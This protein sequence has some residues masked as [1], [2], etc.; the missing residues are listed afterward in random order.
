MSEPLQLPPEQEPQVEQVRLG[1]S[2]LELDPTAAAT[3]RNAFES[4]AAQYSA[5]LETY[6]QQA[7]QTVGT[8]QPM[9]Q[10]HVPDGL[11]V[12]DPDLLFQNKQAWTDEFARS[13]E[14]RI[15]QVEGKN[16]QVAQGLAQAFQQ[17]LNRRD[18][19]QQA[20]QRYDAA[21]AEMLERRGLTECTSLVQGILTEKYQ[22]LQHLPLELAL[23]QIGKEAE[24]AV[25]RIRSGENWEL[26]AAHTQTGVA[27]K[28]PPM[29]RTT[30]RAA[31]PSAPPPTEQGLVSPGGGLGAMG[32]IIRKRQAQVMGG[33]A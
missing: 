26:G 10:F 24:V 3:V 6:R 5:A 18:A 13:L 30:R 15:G 9:P 28:P 8:P 29:L 1:D 14:A 4:L 27:P 17:E 12:P 22:S 32:T 20:T 2:L 23:D 11:G 25:Q 16:I 31:R 33:S 19:A 7:L 21:M